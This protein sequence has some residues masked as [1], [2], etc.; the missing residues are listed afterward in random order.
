MSE[1]R[2]LIRRLMP[3]AFSAPLM[4]S[5]HFQPAFRSYAD[6]FSDNAWLIE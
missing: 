1:W 2:I 3:F 6:V 4:A 5:L